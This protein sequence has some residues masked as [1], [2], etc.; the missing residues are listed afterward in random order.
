MA[1]QSPP[2]FVAFFYLLSI[3]SWLADYGF[4]HGNSNN[5]PLV[6]ISP[7]MTWKQSVNSFQFFAETTPS[8]VDGLSSK[9]DFEQTFGHIFLVLV[10]RSAYRALNLTL[11][12][13]WSLIYLLLLLDQFSRYK[14]SNRNCLRRNFNA[15]H[16]MSSQLHL[17]W[18]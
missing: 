9:F 7:F 17:L 13:T 1:Q 4:L 5:L 15:G 18:G 12:I 8:S 16:C 2:W 10:L 11:T 6:T 14:C 3:S